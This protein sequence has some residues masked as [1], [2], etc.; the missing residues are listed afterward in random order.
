MELPPRARRILLN[1]HPIQIKHG[2]TSAC[3]ENTPA[4]HKE[5][6]YPGNYLRVRGEYKPRG[7]KATIQWE[8]P[9]RA[10][11][12]P[13]GDVCFIGG[14]GT[15]SACAENTCLVPQWRDISRNYL[16][17]R[18][19][20]RVVYQIRHSKSELPPRARRILHCSGGVADSVG[21]TSAC[22]ENTPVTGAVGGLPWSYL[23]VR[24][25]YSITKRP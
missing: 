14:K 21:T 5:H 25:E 8:L 20:Y 2:T 3:A 22:A 1:R 19:E 18:G 10:R 7:V 4:A 6:P 15:T 9:P 23:R 16:R 11:R 24:G 13:S 17:V 12:I